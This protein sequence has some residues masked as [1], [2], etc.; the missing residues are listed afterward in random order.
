MKK[1]FFLEKTINEWFECMSKKSVICVFCCCFSITSALAQA[2]VYD[3]IST[4]G[5]IVD[6]ISGQELQV[7]DRVSFQTELE[8]GSLHDRA[9]LLNDEKAKFFLELPRSAHINSQLV[10]AS[11]QALAPVRV[12][13]TPMTSVRGSSIL[14]VEGV[15][16]KTLRE[17]FSLD[18][19]TIIGSSFTLPVSLCDREKYDLLLKYE[20]DDEIEEYVSSDFTIDRDKL[21]VHGNRVSECFLLLRE[22]AQNTP[23]TQVTITFVEKEQLF[24]E[25]NSLLNAMDQSKTETGAVRAMLRQYCADVYGV[26]DGHSLEASINEFLD[27]R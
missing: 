15:S 13:S 7:G 18:A 24:R 19:Y 23:V 3:I 11:N 9:V 4:T 27:S 20:V 8:F 17:Y 1:Y 22:G 16:P 6:K 21:T 2:G 12:R 14:V 26:I 25:F 10:I 5:T